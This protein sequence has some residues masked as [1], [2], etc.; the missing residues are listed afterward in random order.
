MRITHSE[1]LTAKRR[2]ERSRDNIAYERNRI[3]ENKRIIKLFKNQ[4]W[5]TKTGLTL[6]CKLIS[7]LSTRSINCLHDLF[8]VEGI[9]QDY[10][11]SNNPGNITLPRFYDLTISDLVKF[12]R[13]NVDFRFDKLNRVGKLTNEEIMNIICQFYKV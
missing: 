12:Y 11:Y 2:I 13:K 9:C 4:K 6:N 10:F 8:R 1:Y 5:Q 7:V 3:S